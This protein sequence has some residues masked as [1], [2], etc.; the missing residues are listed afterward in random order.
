[1]RGAAPATRGGQQ[2][3]RVTPDPVPTGAS[4]VA[5]AAADELR[6]VVVAVAALAEVDWHSPAAIAYRQVIDR[7]AGRTALVAALLDRAAVP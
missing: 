2:D 7:L 5:S 3:S 6:P 1:M 4:R